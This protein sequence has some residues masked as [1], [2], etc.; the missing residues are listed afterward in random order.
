M[1][2]NDLFTKNGKALEHADYIHL[3]NDN[4]GARFK[5]EY[6]YLISEAINKRHMTVEKYNVA[7]NVQETLDQICETKGL[8]SR[9]M[10]RLKKLSQ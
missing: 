7:E 2:V 6:K 9:L 1:N 3:F 4:R 10:K 8:E 5:E